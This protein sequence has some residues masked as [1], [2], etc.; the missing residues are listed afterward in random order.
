MKEIE[1]L[2]KRITDLEK[3]VAVIEIA[4]KMHYSALGKKY[5]RGN[6]YDLSRAGLNR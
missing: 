2:K 3:K 1:E 6:P 5:I 4:L